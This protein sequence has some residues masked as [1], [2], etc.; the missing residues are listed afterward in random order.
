[1]RLDLDF[2]RKVVTIKSEVNLKEFNDKIKE[3]LSDWKE[4]K[5]EAVKN[6]LT[7]WPVTYPSYPIINPYTPTYTEPY[8]VTVHSIN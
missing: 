4:W 1:M 7:Y 8:P 3:I 6:E 2:D 5:V